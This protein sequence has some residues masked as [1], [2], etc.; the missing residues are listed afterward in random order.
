[1]D[2]FILVYWAALAAEIVIRYPLQKKWK[3]A[4]KVEQRVSRTE[5]TL[6]SLLWVVMFVLPLIYSLTNWLDFAD[7]RLPAWL[8]WLGV[9]LMAGA[10]LVFARAHIDLKANWSPSL[11]IFEGHT[12]VKSGI[13]G[14]IRHPMYASQWLWVLAQIFLIQNWLAGPVDLLLFIPFYILRVREEEKMMVDTFGEEYR[15]YR[16]AT[17]G[18]W[19]KSWK[20]E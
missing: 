8:G 18:V 7:Y 16:Q 10:L 9:V 5:R 19:P 2:I 1:M 13:Y 20:R 15:Q 12:L 3:A 4:K 11:E 17:G 6:L 14:Y